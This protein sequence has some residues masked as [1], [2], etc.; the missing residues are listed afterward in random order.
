MRKNNYTKK[1][2]VILADEDYKETKIGKKLYLSYDLR[3]LLYGIFIFIFLIGTFVSYFSLYL[4][5]ADRVVTFTEESDVSYNVC[6]EDNNIYPDSCLK[7]GMEYLSVLTKSVNSKF[8]YNVEFS[9]EIEYDLSYKVVA[10]TKVL[11]PDDKKILFETEEEIIAPKRIA[12]ISKEINI[13]QIVEVDYKKYS[14]LVDNYIN[15]YAEGAYALV[16]VELYLIEPTET[17]KL[18][19]LSVPLVG[20]TYNVSKEI[21]S[22][23]DEVRFN[24]NY[25]TDENTI[26]G[27]VGTVNLLLFTF[28]MYRVT[29]LIVLTTRTKSKYQIKLDKILNE[30]DDYIVCSKDG[31]IISE[32][33]NVIKVANFKE[34]LDARNSLNKPII[35]T[36]INNVKCEFIVEDGSTVYQYIMKEVDL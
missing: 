11:S 25:W 33:I 30:F 8:S 29:R 9:S 19:T 17:R 32:G 26:Y 23:S 2:D 20:Q 13:N 34:L 15:T 16:D 35:F 27:V 28:F 24:Y 14:N 12:G 18:S 6:L 4:L 36:K 31:Y 21:L 1:R 10:K 7:E 3:M 22:Y 5:C